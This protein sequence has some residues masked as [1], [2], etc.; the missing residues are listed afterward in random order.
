[1]DN[2]YDAGK[3]GMH[4]CVTF[5]VYVYQ[6]FSMCG[7]LQI[8]FKNEGYISWTNDVKNVISFVSAHIWNYFLCIVVHTSCSEREP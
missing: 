2:N 4:K 8:F 5:P 6:I 3:L 1:M 7:Y